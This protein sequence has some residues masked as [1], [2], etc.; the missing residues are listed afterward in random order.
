MIRACLAY[1]H[2][3]PCLLSLI[4][5]GSQIRNATC[6]PRYVQRRGRPRHDDILTPREWEV[7]DLLRDGLTNEQIAQRL[8]VTHDTAK[9]HVSEIISKLGVATRQEAASWQPVAAGGGRRSGGL[10]ALLGGWFTTTASKT[11]AVAVITIAAG[12]L[13]ALATGLLVMTDRNGDEEGT[14]PEVVASVE[15]TQSPE[16]TPLPNAPNGRTGDPALDAIIEA[17][18]TEDDS[19]LISRFGSIDVYEEDGPPEPWTARLAAAERSLY[20]VRGPTLRAAAL[21]PLDYEII[22]ATAGD[23]YP[24]AWLFGVIDGAVVRVYPPSSGVNVRDYLAGFEDDYPLYLVLPPVED[25]PQPPGGYPLTTRT[26]DSGVDELLALIETNDVDALLDAVEYRSEPCTGALLDRDAC[27][28]QGAT[29]I[30]V[31][32]ATRGDPSENIGP[33]LCWGDMSLQGSDYVQRWFDGWGQPV[34]IH[35]VAT[36]HRDYAPRG[37]VPIGAD[38]EI[39]VVLQLDPYEWRIASLYE[40]DGGIVGLR[41]D[42]EPLYPDPREIPYIIEAPEDG[43]IPPLSRRSGVATVDATMDALQAS[44]AAGFGAQIDPEMVA[45]ITFQAGLGSPPR[46]REGESPETP[47][48]VTTLVACE[49]GYVRLDDLFGPN[50]ERPPAVLNESDWRLYALIEVGPVGAYRRTVMEAVLISSTLIENRNGE[51]WPQTASIGFTSEGISII[52]IGCES[53]PAASVLQRRLSPSFLL[54]PP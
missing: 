18:L 10:A 52:R 49:G 4:R 43:G 8:G 20:A 53:G 11:A 48:R 21:A 23:I 3:V 19:G 7:L 2:T 35:A 33:E 40:R 27:R 22:I 30:D 16:P 28:A 51:T 6:Y 45:C 26:G 46:C 37:G 25:L 14:T 42:R 13:V 9:F 24:A 36:T 29:S 50:A 15:P 54:P 31:L 38:H 1:G 17:L 34:A 41:C 39:F 47:L 12:L 44:D 5:S 32:P